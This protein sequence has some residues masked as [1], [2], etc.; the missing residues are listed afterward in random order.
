MYQFTM[1]E[2]NDDIN[3]LSDLF[4][5][6][7]STKY[8][9]LA[10]MTGILSVKREKTQSA[11]NNF[12]EYTMLSARKFAPYVGFTEKEVKGLC[13]EYH[14][15][16]DKVRYWYDGYMLGNQHVYNPKA[17][18]SVMQRGEF[19]SYWPQTIHIASFV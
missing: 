11:L 4:K 17:V 3:F 7:E 15:D 8:I 12:D 19:R 16:Y 5:G 6:M 13:E 18:A 14:K 9:Q 2:R 10:Y 1:T